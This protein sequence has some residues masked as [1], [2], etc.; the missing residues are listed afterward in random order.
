MSMPNAVAR[1][2]VVGPWVDPIVAHPLP[3]AAWADPLANRTS[4]TQ[5]EPVISLQGGALS[6]GTRELWSGLNL[7]VRPGEFLAVLGPN[8]AG[9][10]SL[11]RVLLG[12]TPLSAGTLQIAGRAARRGTRL[13]GYVPQQQAMTQAAGM[14][15]RDLVRLGIDGDRWGLRGGRRARAQVD[16][17]LRAVGAMS[18][19]DAPLGMLSGGEQQRVRIAQAL[20][21][22]P[23]VLLCDE[24]LLSL[25]LQHQRAVIGLLDARRRQHGTAVVMVTHE[26]N[27]ILSVVDR[28]L[29][30]APHGFRLGSPKEILTSEILTSLYETPV[31]VV[32]TAHGVAI[33]GLN[34][35]P[36][37]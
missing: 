9:K 14:R 17:L 28:V 6:Y 7:D 30:L 29:F 16:G 23:H 32:R 25:D 18:Y 35:A 24:P 37:H 27:P 22:D 12:L 31:E 19:A 15:P 21:G 3:A 8:G 4:T 2:S 1:H 36:V 13:V 20:A 11:L 26:I 10:T 34:V 33:L 5:T